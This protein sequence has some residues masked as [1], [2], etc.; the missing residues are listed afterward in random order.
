MT[1]SQIGV[2]PEGK[3]WSMMSRVL[4]WAGR[5][6]LGLLALVLVAGL[7]GTAWEQWERGQARV[8]YKP[9]GKLVDI[10]GGRRIHIDCRGHG[11]PTVVF[12][13]GLDTN[14]AL[15][16]SAVHD[17][18]ARTTRACAYDRAGIVGSDDKTGPHDADG[19]A[20]DLHAA[21]AAAGEGHPYVLVGHSIGGPYIMD[22]T[23]LYPDEV[24]GLVFVDATHPDQ[25]KRFKAAKLP[26]G[27]T[28]N[29]A[30]IA[31]QIASRTG[32][33]RL[34]SGAQPGP[35][36]VPAAT[37]AESRAMMPQSYPAMIAE[38]KAIVAT[39][40]EAGRLRSLGD[41][42]LVVLSAT[43]PLPAM[44][45]TASGTTA[46]QY[47]RMRAISKDLHTDEASWSSRGRRQEVP[48]S[49]HYI[50]FN[51]P[52]LVIAAVNEVVGE[53]RAGKPAKPPEH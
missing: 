23:R 8:H 37:W 5:I 4:R 11:S 18:V 51:R 3:R 1:Q 32:L 39:L 9:S 7:S 19:V 41:R 43:K 12:E 17:Q 25:L 22:Y 16:W 6:A 14:G 46:D 53:V 38:G 28:N 15:A 48:D 40:D 42:P 49:G 29:S 33:I 34:L 30:L 27:E 21:L 24:A 20:R 2:S 52:D 36:G 13:A 35:K 10:G 44:M 45:I 26:G 50:Q 47:H 31:M